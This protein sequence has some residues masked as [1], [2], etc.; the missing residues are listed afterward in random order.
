MLHRCL[1]RLKLRIVTPH[2]EAASSEIPR[3]SAVPATIEAMQ[4]SVS[5]DSDLSNDG[6]LCNLLR[7]KRVRGFNSP[8]KLVDCRRNESW[9]NKAIFKSVGSGL[10]IDFDEATSL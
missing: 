1:D 4:L 6:M 2:G 7:R 10:K 8:S 9:V 3:V 5:S